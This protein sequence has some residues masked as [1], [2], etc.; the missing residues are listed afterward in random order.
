MQE[1][2]GVS[3]YMHFQNR[4]EA[5]HGEWRQYFEPRIVNGIAIT[6]ADFARMPRWTWQEQDPRVV[7]SDALLRVLQML[8]VTALLAAMCMAKLR[9]YPVV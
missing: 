2:L 6:E 3:R 1:Q 9:R 8:V 4:V 5:F 7:R